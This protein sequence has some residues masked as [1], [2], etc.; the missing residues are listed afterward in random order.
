MNYRINPGQRTGKVNIPASKSYAHRLLI[1]AALADEATTIDCLGIS[2]DIEAT[3][4]C[5]NAL[6]ASISIS[7]DAGTICVNPVSGA[8][9]DSLEGAKENADLFC[10]ESG[11]TLRFLVPVV[12]ALNKNAVFH[13]EGRL[14]K[15]PMDVF[16]DELKKH[17]M[18]FE[19]K[20]DLLYLSGKLTPGEYVIPGDI[21]SQYV[22]GLLYALPVLNGDSVLKVTGNI[23]SK[24]Y[25]EMTE[26][27][28]KSMG[29][30]FEKDGFTYRI[31]GN[32]RYKS[33]KRVRV[34]S[35]WSNAAFFLCMGALSKEGIS[36]D[37][38]N[39]LSKQGDRKI[40][41]ILKGFGA[42]VSFEAD[43]LTVKRGNLEGQRID[44]S[45]IPDLVPT[46]C[47][48]ASLSNGQTIIYNAQRLRFKESDRIKSTA[49]MINSVGGNATITEDGLIIEGK[50]VLKGGT[51]DSVNDHR[52][53]MASAVA[54]NGCE[55]EVTVLDAECI[56]KSYPKFWEDL[57]SLE[58]TNEQ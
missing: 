51:V 15:R 34:E 54:A 13:M 28:I 31:K 39:I 36:M 47:A 20:G 5:L 25:I 30:S 38:M 43:R 7:E 27:I 48:L 19:Q 50:P 23:E 37:G 57:E 9:T 46:I 11:S 3:I 58:V 52:I 16:T 45:E 14:S 18:N 40:V 4:D 53:A 21:S 33:V 29:I 35:D 8:D 42:A 1:C 55:S 24:S 2:K 41:E 12:G 26:E 44:A 17:G 56:Q 6:G 49:D 32:Q 22:S 10:K